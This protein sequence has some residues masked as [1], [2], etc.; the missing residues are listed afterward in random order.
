M[1]DDSA[2]AGELRRRYERGGTAH[3]SELTAS[4]LRARYSI[5]SNKEG[6]RQCG[7]RE[8]QWSP[9]SSL[10]PLFSLPCFFPNHQ[11]G[12]INPQDHRP[13]SLPWP[14]QRYLRSEWQGISSS[15]NRKET[16]PLVSSTTEVHPDEAKSTEKTANLSAELETYKRSSKMQ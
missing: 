14:S 4:Q 2:S 8:E 3:D 12:Q 6:Q 7:E 10:M 16:G 1:A 15:S 13:S 9:C 5:P 11:A